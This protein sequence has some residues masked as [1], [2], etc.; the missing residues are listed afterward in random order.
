MPSEKQLW[1]EEGKKEYRRKAYS[2]AINFFNHRIRDDIK[3]TEAWYFKGKAWFKLGR[4]SEAL[5]CFQ[6]VIDI[7]KTHVK[8]WARVGETLVKMERLEEAL[9]A[10][11]NGIEAIGDSARLWL[12]KSRVFIMVGATEKANES[13]DHAL[14]LDP[15]LGDAWLEKG[16]LLDETGVFEGAIDCYTKATRLNKKLSDAWFLKGRALEQLGRYKEAI[17]CYDWTTKMDENNIEAWY[18]KGN[19][20]FVLGRTERAL[21]TFEMVLQLDPEHRDAIFKVG[22][23][24]EEMGNVKLALQYYS[25]ADKEEGWEETLTTKGDAFFRMDK[26]DEALRAYDAALETTL[27]NPGAWAGKGKIM[28][29]EKKY[30]EAV[31]CLNQSI[32]FDPRNDETWHM[33]ANALFN[34]HKY[35]EAFSCFDRAV[36][37][38]ADNIPILLDK[39]M[40][41]IA[42]SRT[43]EAVGIINEILR[44]EADNER[45]MTMLEMLKNPTFRASTPEI[46][47]QR[48]VYHNSKQSLDQFRANIMLAESVKV[49]VR[50]FKKALNHAVNE[51]KNNNFLGV[52]GIIKSNIKKLEDACYTKLSDYE[53]DTKQLLQGLDVSVD[54]S[55]VEDILRKAE[56]ALNEKQ[57]KQTFDHLESTLDEIESLSEMSERLSAL[58]KQDPRYLEEA[59]KTLREVKKLVK[60]A[61]KNNLDPSHIEMLVEKASISEL[62][63]DY[64][65]AANIL[66]DAKKYAR[67][68]LVTLSL[69]S[70]IGELEKDAGKAIKRADETLKSLRTFNFNYP[71]SE[72][73]L[74]EARKKLM[75]KAFTEAYIAAKRSL[76]IIHRIEKLERFV[77][78]YN[79]GKNLLTMT[80][81]FKNFPTE[82]LATEIR[83]AKDLLMKKKINDALNIL[84]EHVP[85]FSES[86]KNKALQVKLKV[87]QQKIIKL[88][89]LGKD[90][91]KIEELVVKSQPSLAKKDYDMAIRYV[92]GALKLANRMLA[93]S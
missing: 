58:R 69:E 86:L 36:E 54:S 68:L 52:M 91:S 51:M 63:K 66:G 6:K 13:L 5:S 47:Q 74:E 3:D 62:K 20:L 81:K 79:E 22:Q 11:E 37:Y 1:L 26:L 21:E 57:Y 40:S 67:N 30:K 53:R 93:L 84:N 33:K 24:H 12:G 38:S 8:S 29:I 16:R 85:P 73:L 39:T 23:I 19:S 82:K 42:L 7:D 46:R 28:M 25:L 14:E 18:S 88:K 59:R 56:I 31:E 34:L 87:T 61:Y 92:E 9:H 35:G 15:D 77:E 78:L 44:R 65:D 45:A 32:R 70:S 10:Y 90:I 75:K 27:N 43:E 76:S 2:E 4:L 41:L 71:N 60:E 64:I 49:D 80:R 89:K 50:P 72:E 48:D 17:R 83:K 55:H